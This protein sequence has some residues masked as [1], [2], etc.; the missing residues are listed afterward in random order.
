MIPVANIYLLILTHI[1]Y[2]LDLSQVI[3]SFSFEHS[4]FKKVKMIHY[5]LKLDKIKKY[6]THK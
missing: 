6:N 3:M 1:S 5:F 2:I 4:S